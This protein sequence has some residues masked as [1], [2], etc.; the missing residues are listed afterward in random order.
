MGITTQGTLIHSLYS[1]VETFEKR[2]ILFKAKEGENFNHRNTL[3]ILSERSKCFRKYVQSAGV[4]SLAGEFGSSRFIIRITTT[5]T[6]HLTAATGSCC[7]FTVTTMSTRDMRW[8][9][10]MARQHRTTSGSHPLTTGRSL[11]SRPC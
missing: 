9:K 5:I 3:S 4:N 10:R 2:S 8:P 11:I 1:V 6:I 7:V